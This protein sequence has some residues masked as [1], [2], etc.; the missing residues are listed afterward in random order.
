MNHTWCHLP[1]AIKW[2]RWIRITLGL[3]AHWDVKIVLSFPVPAELC[4]GMLEYFCAVE[5][6]WNVSST[7]PIPFTIE[8][9]HFQSL[10]NVADAE[11]NKVASRSIK[12][13]HWDKI[14]A[15]FYFLHFNSKIFG[16][17]FY[18]NT[19]SFGAHF[20]QWTSNDTE[21]KSVQP[22]PSHAYKL[23]YNQ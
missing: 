15:T 9:L 10:W 23:L 5:Q 16:R 14:N 11:K 6:I 17:G 22:N 4:G 2:D 19:G 1:S 7:C 20:S 3:P 12:I 18:R 21:Y 8:P 13:R